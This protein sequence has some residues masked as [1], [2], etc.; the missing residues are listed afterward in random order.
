MAR[1]VDPKPF[2]TCL[3]VVVGWPQKARNTA[4]SDTK[5]LE[6]LRLGRSALPP[7]H[8]SQCSSNPHLF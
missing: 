3:S 6:L 7:P 2:C 8:H 5:V 4:R 1:S